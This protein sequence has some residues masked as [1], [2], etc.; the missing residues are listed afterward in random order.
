MQALMNSRQLKKPVFGRLGFPWCLWWTTYFFWRERSYSL[1]LLDLY[2]QIYSTSN[3]HVTSGGFLPVTNCRSVESINTMECLEDAENLQ[4]WNLNQW[5]VGSECWPYK[6]RMSIWR[7]LELLNP[8]NL[9]GTE[10][11]IKCSTKVN[12]LLKRIHHLSSTG[13]YWKHL[14]I[15][16]ATSFIQ[17]NDKSCTCW[18]S[19]SL[20]MVYFIWPTKLCCITWR[21]I[22]PD[23]VRRFLPGRQRRWPVGPRWCGRTT[24]WG[25]V[26]F[27]A[28]SSFDA[29]VECSWF[30]GELACWILLVLIRLSTV[31]MNEVEVEDPCRIPICSRVPSSS[32]AHRLYWR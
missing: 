6:R 24:L 25:P 14:I 13:D 5:T 19:V 12:W 28:C 18:D 3:G 20:L 9:S 21:M 17:L 29:N 31:G 8:Y 2:I 32:S 11:S 1:D 30:T 26:S 7:H 27:H 10:E 22:L 16:Q 4:I 23:L 15:K